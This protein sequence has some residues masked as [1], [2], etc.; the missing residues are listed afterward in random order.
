VSSLITLD[1]S[2]NKITDGIHDLI[3]DI[4]RTGINILL[5]KGNYFTGDIPRKLCELTDLNILDLSYN[6]FVGEI[7]SCLG[8]MPFKNKDPGVSRWNFNEYI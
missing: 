7:P 6:N 4:R 2:N 1:L 3:H 8:E 5:L